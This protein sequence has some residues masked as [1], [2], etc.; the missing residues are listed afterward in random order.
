MRHPLLALLA[1]V[2]V[3]ILTGCDSQPPT[4]HAVQL[5]PPAPVPITPV[6]DQTE[7]ENLWNATDD[8]HQLST[9]GWDPAPIYAPGLAQV[10]CYPKEGHKE[11]LLKSLPQ[12]SYVKE[13]LCST[14]SPVTTMFVKAEIFDGEIT[15]RAYGPPKKGRC[16]IQYFICGT[17]VHD[18]I[19]TE[20]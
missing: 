20:E 6:E 8:I 13:G 2:F 7:F 9:I 3:S 5:P 19:P 18:T 14:N 1:L 15:D 17:T 16:E 12:N 4:M 10:L 11:A